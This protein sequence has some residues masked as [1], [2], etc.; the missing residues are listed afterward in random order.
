MTRL[1]GLAEEKDNY[2]T[3]TGQMRKGR[4]VL[5]IVLCPIH[6]LARQVQEEL[7]EVARPLGLS[8]MVFHG[9]VSYD[10]QTCALRNGLGVLV[11]TPVWFINHVNNGNLDQSEDDTKQR[12]GWGPTDRGGAKMNTKEGLKRLKIK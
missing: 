3:R 10:P 12:H 8:T 11:G 4:A 2:D 5:I 9:G 1:R 6:E 7:N